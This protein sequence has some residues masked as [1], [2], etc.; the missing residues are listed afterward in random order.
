M[1]LTFR[2][3]PEN[4]FRLLANAIYETL[5]SVSLRSAPHLNGAAGALGGAPVGRLASPHDARACRLVTRP[6]L[7]ACPSYRPPIVPSRLRSAP[8]RRP[9]TVI[10]MTDSP[11][12]IEATFALWPR[13]S[14]AASSAAAS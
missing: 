11:L 14:S 10:S 2:G 4:S 8:P 3:H 1:D 7:A 12:S 6:L 13:A 5:D 9:S